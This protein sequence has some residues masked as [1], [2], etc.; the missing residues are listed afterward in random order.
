MPGSVLGGEA[1]PGWER[2]HVP[3]FK[4]PRLFILTEANWLETQARV[5]LVLSYSL[6]SGSFILKLQGGGG[7]DVGRE[8]DIS[9][10]QVLPTNCSCCLTFF[11]VFTAS[12]GYCTSLIQDS[13]GSLYTSSQMSPA[14]ALGNQGTTEQL[15]AGNE[16]P[17]RNGLSSQNH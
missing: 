4:T 16:F 7:L 9:W 10:R 17:Q 11:F 1:T 15:R 12:W 14:P 13:L 3:L 2:Y 6:Q 8:E 5:P